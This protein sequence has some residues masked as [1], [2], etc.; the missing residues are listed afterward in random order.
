M[1]LGGV[2]EGDCRALETLLA[3][4]EPYLHRVIAHRLDP[5]MNARVDPADVLQETH[6]QITSRIQ[7]FLTRRP[8]PFRLWLRKTACECLLQV[9]RKHVEAQARSVDREAL[10]ACQSSIIL[11]ERLLDNATSPS[12]K[13]VKREVSERVRE[14]VGDLSDQDSEILVLRAYEGL[15]NSEAACVLS[16][17]VDTC[18]KRY[19]RA[20]LRLSQALNDRGLSEVHL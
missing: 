3:L 20:L 13:I 16:I 17:E 19:T 12:G 15:T 10:L 9:R 6:L 14:A 2:S 18:R 1:L 7:D 11:A 5:R 8:M 4:H